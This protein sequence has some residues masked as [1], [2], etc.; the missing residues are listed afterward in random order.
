M[1]FI[2]KEIINNSS[3]LIPNSSVADNLC[4]SFIDFSNP[5]FVLIDGLFF[6]TLL[7][8]NY[9]REMEALFL[10][11]VLSL[12]IDTNISMY[13]DKQKS[14]DIIKE[15]TYTIGNVGADIKTSN[16]NQQD[17]EVVG[18]TYG[19]AKYIRKMLQLG[20]E[21][22]FYLTIQIGVFA[23]SKEEL[24]T[25]VERIESVAVSCGLTTIRANFRQEQAIKT[26]L[27][28]NNLDDD[29]KSITRRNV[30]TSG[31]TATY[32][33]V[34]NELFD[35]KGVLI[36]TN[37]FDKSIL[38]LDRFAT[39]KYKNANMFVVGTS[40]SG[41]S[42]FV[43]LMINRNRFLNISQ[44]VVDP[45]REYKKL[46][47]SLNGTMINFG[48]NQ[49][50]NVFD[51]REIVLEEGESF[52]LNKI[53][54]LKVFFS[55]IFEKMSVE[56]RAILEELLIRCYK[57]KDI[58]EDNNS[59][60]I[61]NEKSKLIKK[62]IFRP[63]QMMPKME[64]FYNLLK[65]NKA[66]K[67]YA[68][69]LKPYVLG[70]FKYLNNHTN[71]S[72]DNKL[73]VIDVHDFKDDEMPI[74]MFIVTEYFWD[75]IKKNRGEKKLLYLDEVW[76]LINKNEYTAEFVFNLFK[77]IR[78]YGGGATAITQ[79]ISDFFMLDNGKYGKGILN[80]SAIKCIFQLEETDINILEK[81]INISEEEKYRLINMKRGTAIIHADRNTLMVDVV[82]S[83][84]EHERITTD[85]EDLEKEIR[86]KNDEENC[87]GT[88]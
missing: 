48:T 62:R 21:Q 35:K 5:Q 33:F 39:S 66:L 76:K 87:Y 45:D 57:E 77:T 67:K 28:F 71:I 75:V 82:A 29:I 68:T 61:E 51:I 65:N 8:I 42:Y 2:T 37:T 41:K 1:S 22:L 24:E 40:G 32:P 86:R 43:K 19:D 84:K 46:C 69:I 15:L 56:E 12:D 23:K 7:V 60:Y 13:Y 64:D 31:L 55:I 85:R 36:G 73:V 27:P 16:E 18:S 20:E 53:S 6:S 44:F 25:D 9:S 50:I 59:L 58:T 88:W 49:M 83:K 74:I 70:S 11:K 34:S 81:V 3:T 52:L 78:K 10:D 30:L 38:M 80:N 72:I 47:E 79:D 63:P 26:I 54:K 17:I 14:Y 4:S